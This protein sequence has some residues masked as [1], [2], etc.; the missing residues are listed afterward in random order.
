MRR[1]AMFRTPP[2]QSRN[3]GNRT[4]F[5]SEQAAAGS[6]PSADRIDAFLR[7]RQTW[8]VWAACAF[9]VIRILVFAAAFPLFNTVDEQDHYEMVYKFSR[10]YLPEKELP[11]C[12][13]EMARI[14]ALYGSPEYLNSLERLQSF[15]RDVP[16]AKLPADRKEYH[17]KK[18]FDYW[19]SSANIEAQSPPMYYIVAAGWYRL[20]EAWGGKDW[21]LAYWVR[22]LNAILY[23]VFVWISYLFAKE[24]YPER[25]FLCVGVPG[26]LAVIPQDVFYGVNRGVLS[27]L[28]AAL[29]LLLLFRAMREETRLRYLVT[30]GF[31]TG[32]AFLTD[33]SNFVLF[34]VFALALYIADRHAMKAGGSSKVLALGFSAAGAVLLP[35]LWMV[36]NRLVM[37]DLTGS[38]AKTTTLHWTPKPW[39]EIWHH[40]IFS[41]S[42]LTYF[43][44]ELTHSYWRGE[45]V[46]AGAPIRAAFADGF[47]FFSSLAMLLVFLGYVASQGKLEGW[48]QRLS[49]FVSLYLVVASVAFLG[50][51][52]LFFDFQDCI[53][54]SRKWPYFVSGRIICGTL[55]PFALI[56]L[57]GFEFL[58]RPIRRYVH[59]IFLLLVILAGITYSEIVVT[60][61]VFASHFNYF[62]WRFH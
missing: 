62:A 25:D 42:G 47:Y 36:R 55:L 26:L 58:V 29:A 40:P 22:F 11:I 4:G 8:I 27:P 61:P 17:Y 34:G 16:I 13:P 15:G 24:I 52:S 28:L 10:G 32:I 39:P 43:L 56:Y 51:I 12:D 20:G 53:Y 3:K 54:P 44:R 50:V 41:M 30:G 5:M 14:F 31:L 45:Y 33:V 1:R 7:R 18:V 35:L 38:W 59:P 21:A 37:G 23:G 6:Q 19:A 49:E 9:A 48:L 46:W 2:K 57:T 60:R